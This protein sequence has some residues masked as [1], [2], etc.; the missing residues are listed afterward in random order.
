[1]EITLIIDAELDAAD[2]LCNIQD[3][4]KEHIKMMCKMAWTELIL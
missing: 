3:L 2:W 4:H 1:M